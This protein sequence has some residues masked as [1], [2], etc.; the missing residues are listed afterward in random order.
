MVS[1]QTKFDQVVK[2]LRRPALPPP[3]ISIF[4]RNFFVFTQHSF[5]CFAGFTFFTAAPVPELTASH[6]FQT[7]G[8]MFGYSREILYQH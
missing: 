4:Y 7:C 5:G 2:L 8:T 3:P 6:S 1:F